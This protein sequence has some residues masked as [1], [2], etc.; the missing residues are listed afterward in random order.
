M[1]VGSQMSEKELQRLQKLMSGGQITPAEK[2][3]I[4]QQIKDMTGSQFSEK[5]RNRIK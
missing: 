5:E 3:R 4:M 2:K 1:Y